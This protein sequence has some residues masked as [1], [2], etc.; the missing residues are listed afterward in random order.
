M[1]SLSRAIQYVDLFIEENLIFSRH[2]HLWL[3]VT[4]M[5]EYKIL[6]IDNTFTFG[7]AINSLLNLFKALNKDKYLPILITGQPENFL[8]S[9]FKGFIYYSLHFKLPWVN[10]KLHKK[11]ISLRICQNKILFKIINA[12]RVIYWLI[13]ITLPESFR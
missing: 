7:G 9:R 1:G 2:A 4:D 13:C 12:V 10:N 3:R 5:A 8:A 6:Y 11:I